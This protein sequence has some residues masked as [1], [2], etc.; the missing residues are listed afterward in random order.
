MFFSLLFVLV[1][2]TQNMIA[3]S[4]LDQWKKSLPVED[5]LEKSVTLN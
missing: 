4:V 5:F 1:G 2:S 3:I